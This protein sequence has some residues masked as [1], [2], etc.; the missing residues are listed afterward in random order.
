MAADPQEPPKTD[1]A[2]RVAVL[3]VCTP[4]GHLL[5]LLSLKPAWGDFTHA[6]VTYD[7]SD[8]RSL[9]AVGHLALSMNAPIDVKAVGC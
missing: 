7:S 2:G 6:W 5:Q 8:A 3:L 1:T 4:G 9:L